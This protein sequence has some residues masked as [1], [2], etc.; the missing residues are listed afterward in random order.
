MYSRVR[1]LYLLLVPVLVLS[2]IAAG[3]GKK[4]EAVEETEITVNIAKAEKRDIAKSVSY[5][6]IVRGENEVYIMPKVMARV[7]AIYVKPGDP[8][9][10]GQ[11]LLVLD[12]SDYEAAVKQ[13]EAALAQAEAAK[14]ANDAQKETALANYE[15]MK[16]LHEAGAVSDQ[17]LEQA[18]SQYEALAAGSAEAAVEQAR[19][20]LLQAQTQ[21]NHCIIKSPI[22]GVVGSINLSLGDTANPQSPAAV[23]T[24]TSRLEIEVLVS[25]SEVSYIETGSEVDV[26]IS[27]VQD[28]PFAGKVKSVAAVPDPVKRNY[29][30]KVA[31]DN[32][33]NNIRSGMFAEVSIA[34][35]SKDDVLCVPRSAVIPKG[36][37]NI[38]YTVDKESRAREK[39]VTTGI[40][41]SSYIEI[42]KGIEEG[43]KVI[44]RGNTLVNDGTRVRVITGGEK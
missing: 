27:A 30:V 44:T 39:E 10:E 4:E 25:E 20:G 7:T 13:A 40:E 6:G 35:I 32:Q 11:T 38:I 1:G 24:D 17:Q 12:S 22:N 3:C 29:A 31:L 41:N 33:D 19:A 37:R 9:R 2:L 43:E 15:R 42:L 18:R 26:F 14:R 23:V 34:T 8:V 36:G 21:L 28:E 5:S 16:K